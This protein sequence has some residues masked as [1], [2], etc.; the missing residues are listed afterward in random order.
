MPVSG[1]QDVAPTTTH[2]ATGIQS[3]DALLS[4][5]QYAPDAG[6]TTTTI[7]F[8]FGNAESVFYVDPIIGYETSNLEP[9]SNFTELSEYSKGLFLSAIA[10][11]ERYTN[12]DFQQVE[13][14]A[15]TAGTVRVTWS[16]L[17]DDDAV[18][19]AYYPGNT[20]QAGDIWLISK[21]H[22]E[23]DVDYQHTLLH[24]LGHALGLSHS[25]TAETGFSKIQ[26]QFE[27][28]DFTVMSYTVSARFTDATWADL[29]PQSYMYHDIVA[30]QEVYGKDEV[31]TAGKDTYQFDQAERYLQTVWDFGGTDTLQITNGST[32]THLDLTPGSW[33]NVG[34]SIRYSRSNGSTFNDSYTVYIAD[35]TIIENATGAGGNDTIQ[36]NDANN[37]L[38]GNAGD[39][40]LE[41]AS[42]NDVLR[43]GAGS[44]ISVGGLGNDQLWAG[45]D[46]DAA[47]TL[48]GGDGNDIL[49]GG[50]GS[51]FIVGGSVNDGA[52]SQISSAATDASLDGNDTVY[53][54]DGNDTII[55]GGW[56][57]SAVTD[58]GQFDVGEQVTSGTG[59]DELWAGTGND[60]IYATDGNDQLGGGQGDD[61]IY[62]A[63]GDDII[64]GGK[65]DG[66]DTGTNDYIDAGAGNDQILAS[67]GNDIIIAGSGDDDIFGGGG[68]DTVN[69][70]SGDDTL[71]GGGGDDDFTGGS[72]ADT[73]VFAAGHG[74][75]TV[76]DFDVVEDIL[77]IANTTTDFNSAAE[78][79]AAAMAENGGVTID[80]GGGDTVF[81]QGISLNDL[82][83]VT[84]NFGE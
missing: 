6:S 54:G 24:E 35:D 44:D 23:T 60:L 68:N 76:Q 63:G 80:I 64:Y 61:S 39:D 3:V 79:R 41:G 34:T 2:T 16:D 42:G 57:D 38:I 15:T 55:G 43:G 21:N 47:D 65:S 8:S 58:N 27:G 7:T 25:F 26:S 10:E 81:L 18:G 53:G 52:T 20:V 78:V 46:D 32:A 48:T 11:I 36:G 84:Y 40:K 50:A 49:A 66:A 71:W 75:E 82:D 51:D 45:S 77:F 14:T 19:W 31:T 74:N 59:N 1:V 83:N 28:V 73:F 33:S 5:R 22:Q 17:N 12:I 9:T 62:A 30:L 72:G 56:D 29:W 4:G 13:E 67:G 69:G 70:G 37:R